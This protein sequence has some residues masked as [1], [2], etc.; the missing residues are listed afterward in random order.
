MVLQTHSCQRSA[1]GAAGDA[2]FEN[3]TREPDEEGE[4]RLRDATQ[5]GRL[6]VAEAFADPSGDSACLG[7]RPVKAA[8]NRD[9]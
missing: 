5:T 7:M 9:C 6:E 3:V 8:E 1:Q 2:C 4:T